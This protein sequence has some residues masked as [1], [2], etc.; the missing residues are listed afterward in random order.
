MSDEEVE[1]ID[2]NVDGITPND[3]NAF[4]SPRL[5]LALVVKPVLT[6]GDLEAWLKDFEIDQRRPS[7]VDRIQLL[8]CALKANIIVHSTDEL[9]ALTARGLDGRKAQWYG[10]QLMKVYNRYQLID[11]N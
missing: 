10:A 8:F 11:P 3:E 2:R 9:T 4:T 5:G 7:M 6:A 1:V